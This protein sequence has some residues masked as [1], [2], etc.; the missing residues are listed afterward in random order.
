MRVPGSKHHLKSK[1]QIGT[2]DREKAESRRVLQFGNTA[3]LLL[4]PDG[5]QS[6]FC[7]FPETFSSCW[8]LFACWEGRAGFLKWTV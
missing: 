8:A 6:Q 7:I 1:R 3:P 5:A 4:H 2:N